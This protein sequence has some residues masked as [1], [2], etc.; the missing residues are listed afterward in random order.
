MVISRADPLDSR[1]AKLGRYGDGS[2]GLAVKAPAETALYPSKILE[3]L[4][5]KQE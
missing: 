5:T 2:A 4:Y 1:P 3:D